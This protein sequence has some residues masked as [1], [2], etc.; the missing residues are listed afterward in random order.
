MHEQN[1]GEISSISLKTI[2]YVF[3]QMTVPNV[4]MSPP[5]IVRETHEWLMIDKAHNADATPSRR[6]RGTPTSLPGRSGS[7][8]VVGKQE[9]IRLLPF[10]RD[11]IRILN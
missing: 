6:Q 4:E 9:V 8:C 3:C 11:P 1:L 5:S 10:A 7:G 2:R